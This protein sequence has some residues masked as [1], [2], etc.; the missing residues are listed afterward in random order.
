MSAQG[1]KRSEDGSKLGIANEVLVSHLGRTNI[2]KALEAG[3][4]SIKVSTQDGSAADIAATSE[5]VA[6]ASDHLDTVLETQGNPK[7]KGTPVFSFA[8][9]FRTNRT[10]AGDISAAVY[11]DKVELVPRHQI[12][13]EELHICR[14]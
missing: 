3:G 14:L 8:F 5:A 7:I 10:L 9:T 2:G 1:P 12:P 11:R 4:F 6:K 13:T